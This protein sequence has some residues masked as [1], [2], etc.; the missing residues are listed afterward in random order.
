VN[1]RSA[2]RRRR[3]APLLV[4][5]YAASL[6]LV[7]G[8]CAALAFVVSSHVTG[9]AMASS[10]AADA[11]FVSGFVQ[12]FIGP[13]D[14]TAA[15]PSPGRQADIDGRLSALVSSSG[16][17]RVKV[18]SPDGTILFS[19]VAAL[20]GRN[21]G[22]E[23]D[24]QEAFAGQPFADLTDG[25]SG[26]ERGADALPA[27]RV[28][29]EYLPVRTSTGISLVFEIYRD[30]APII[31]NVEA[32]RRD[33]IVITLAA[34]TILAVLLYLMFR[35][36]QARLSRQ[37]RELLEAERGDALT[38]LLNH[39]SVVAELVGLIEAARSVG[40]AVG[41]AIVD[42]DN[43]RLLNE[44]HGHAAGDKALREVARILRRELSQQSIV[45]RYGPDEFLV[46]APPA[47]A[48]DL[49]A[50]IGRLQAGLLDLSLQFGVSERLPVTV[51]AGI[52][53]APVDGDAATELLS[54]ATVTLVEAKA[55][56]GDGIR[57]AGGPIAGLKASEQSSFDVLQG[58]VIAVDTKDR[59]T[60]RHSE[61]VARYALFIADRIG[62]EADSRRI[63]AMAGLLHDVGKIGIPDAILRKP[64]ALTADE[65]AIVKQHVA[66]G[67]MITRDLPNIDLV[68]GGVRHHHERWDGTGYLDGLAGLDIPLFARILAVADAFSAMTTSR[69][70]R[71]AL[72]VEEA[73]RRLEDAAD[74]Q[75][76]PAMVIAFVEGL[77]SASDAPLPGMDLPPPLLWTP[78][79]NVA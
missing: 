23:E 37:T 73:I 18:Y 63:L 7:A 11:S 1:L 59:Y 25:D 74:S 64:A 6:T 20:R 67:D 52:C 58:L 70:Y 26:E 15:G 56:G 24:L 48:H 16:M 9:T 62:M 46:I 50:A 54:V 39:G 34:A 12:A 57:I 32:S 19:D 41:V 60:K 10:V 49:E 13:E 4:L 69:P 14:L 45:G 38:G 47:C 71:K 78:R 65:Y 30:A 72:D 31:A 21:F 77:R 68:R 75:L 76:D 2:L 36:A 53:F 33:T 29:E 51:S 28:L 43:F 27:E 5:V 61:D 22:L 66:L 79:A 55:S 3:R 17:L 42:V 35:A 40:G 44:A 8:T